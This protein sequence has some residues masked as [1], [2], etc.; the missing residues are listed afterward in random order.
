MDP[1]YMFETNQ[2]SASSPL[3]EDSS[4]SLADT[5]GCSCEQILFCKPGENKG[6]MKYG[7]TAATM[8]IWMSQSAW[9]LDCQVDGMVTLEGEHEGV[10]SDTDSDAVVDLLDGDDDNDGIADAM[11]SEE[12]SKADINGNPTGKPDWWCNEHPNK[13]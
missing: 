8:S 2:G 4:Y 12:D 9:S 6:E 5:Y 1:D 13:C 11:D 7:C 3:I 10:L